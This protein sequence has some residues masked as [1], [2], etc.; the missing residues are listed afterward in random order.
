MKSNLEKKYN[1]FNT[2]THARTK[3]KKT[4][5][6]NWNVWFDSS[7]NSREICEQRCRSAAGFLMHSVRWALTK[8]RR[9]ALFQ[10]KSRAAVTYSAEGADGGWLTAPAL[11]AVNE[12]CMT[13]LKAF[14]FPLPPIKV[15][16]TST[17]AQQ[18][19]AARKWP[20]PLLRPPNFPPEVLSSFSSTHYLR[21]WGF[22]TFRARNF[23]VTIS[24]L[25][26]YIYI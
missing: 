23:S 3:K 1:C 5:K 9:E 4:K 8:R 24:A 20:F 22:W 10:N 17:Y 26:F 6:E 15:G 21:R 11:L 16:K 7:L 2:H 13:D 12:V 19:A 25:V 18:P 14:R